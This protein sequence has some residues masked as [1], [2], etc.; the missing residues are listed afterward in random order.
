MTSASVE[1]ATG[2]ART[3]EEPP[4]TRERHSLHDSLEDYEQLVAGLK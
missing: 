3:S 1:S 2:R 4:D